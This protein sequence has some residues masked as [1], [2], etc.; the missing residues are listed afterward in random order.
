[1]VP[2]DA[3]IA[4]ERIRWYSVSASRERQVLSQRSREVASFYTEERAIKVFQKAVEM[5]VA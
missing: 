1:M 2:L 5:A 3:G 4:A